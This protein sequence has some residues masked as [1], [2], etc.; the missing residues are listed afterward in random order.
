MVSP[1]RG[2]SKCPAQAHITFGAS[3]GLIAGALLQP[4]W[5]V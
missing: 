4:L 5:A 3:S 2:G 1:P